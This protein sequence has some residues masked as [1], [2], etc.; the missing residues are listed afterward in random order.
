MS[1]EWMSPEKAAAQWDIKV[2]QVQALCAAGHVDGAVKW[3]RVWL[4]PKD[5]PKPI[6]G[7]TKAAKERKKRAGELT[8]KKNDRC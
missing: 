2:R 5:T 6:D 4:I 7:R 8:G 1:I 3:G